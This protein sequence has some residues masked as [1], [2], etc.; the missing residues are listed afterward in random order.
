MKTVYILLILTVTA[1]GDTLTLGDALKRALAHN[2]HIG[3][4]RHEAR[5]AQ[6]RNHA[7]VHTFLPSVSA[8]ARAGTNRQ[9][10]APVQERS[11]TVRGGV[12]LDWTLFDGFK[13]FYENESANLQ[14]DIQQKKSRRAVEETVLDVCSRFYRYAHAAALTAIAHTQIERTANLLQQ[15]QNGYDRGAVPRGD[16]LAMQ[17]QLN[18]DSS[19]L[20]TARLDSMKAAH[21]LNTALGREPDHDLRLRIAPE[22]QLLHRDLAWWLQK[23][24]QENRDVQITR[25]TLRNAHLQEEI[26]KAAYR[27][28]IRLSSS[29]EQSLSPGDYTELSASVQLNIPLYDGH[30][31]S[32]EID[33]AAAQTAILQLQQKQQRLSLTAAVTTLWQ[34]Y[35]NA[36]DQLTFEEDAVALAKE[37][38]RLRTQEYELGS[39]DSPALRKAQIDLLEARSRRESARYEGR[40]LALKIKYTAGQLQF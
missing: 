15:R 4:A 16:L 34:E 5:A 2:H 8:G 30:V 22:S 6:L 18:S 9:Y 12:Y 20:A 13:M 39:G 19:R 29:A 11:G 14:E 36:R 27:P 7:A 25:S 40:I 33:A 10:P 24:R 32:R 37:N 1:A 23:A 31:R 3:I 28:N 35:Q 26:T 17:V 38:L 21:E